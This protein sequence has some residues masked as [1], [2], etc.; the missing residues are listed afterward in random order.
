[1]HYMLL[2]YSREAEWEGASQA[3]QAAIMR[4]HDE[5]EGDLR[6]AGEYHGCGAL[7]PVAAARTVRAGGDGTLV[8]DGPFAETKEQLGGYYLI[9]AN[10]MDEAIS[11][12]ARIPGT[13]SSAVEVRPIVDCHL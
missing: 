5:L 12:A 3:E 7:A 10:D 9:E 8:T 2:I 13:S 11:I 1:M 4:R 6:T